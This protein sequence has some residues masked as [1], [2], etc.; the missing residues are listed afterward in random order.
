MKQRS[1]RDCDNV[2]GTLKIRDR[3]TNLVDRK[4]R[5]RRARKIDLSS[6]TE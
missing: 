5:F 3:E 4:I 1:R 2:F 6:G